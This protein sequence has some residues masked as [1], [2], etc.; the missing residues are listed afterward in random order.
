MSGPVEKA[1]AAWGEA[2]PDWVEALARA[3][4]ASSQAKVA[5]RLDRSD[6]LVSD[7]LGKRYR[8]NMAAVEETVRGVL[9]DAT[10]DCPALG[11]LPSHECQTWRQRARA[12]SGHNALRVQMYR[13][14]ARCPRNRREGEA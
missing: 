11:L 9:M 10:V 7:V 4:A 13:A 1:R 3:C 2:M 5:R 12:F 14:C 6:A 8:G